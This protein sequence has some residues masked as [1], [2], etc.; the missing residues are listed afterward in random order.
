MVGR[1]LELIERLGAAIVERQSGL[2]LFGIGDEEAT[3]GIVIQ[4]IGE[5]HLLTD[6]ITALQQAL[7]HHRQQHITQPLVEWT[8]VRK[9]N[10]LARPRL[11]LIGEGGGI[12]RD[13]PGLQLRGF[14]LVAD[15]GY[16]RS[17]A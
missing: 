15:Q 7:L 12:A 8:V 11:D 4:C 16:R 13:L 1:I 9:G 5:M 10:L 6:L 3:A 2:H 14:H 17:Q